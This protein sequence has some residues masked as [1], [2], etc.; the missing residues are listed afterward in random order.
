MKIKYSIPTVLF[1]CVLFTACEQQQSSSSTELA[2]PVSVTEVQ[3]SNIKK[4][5]ST[6]G[7]AL[8]T[9]EVEL[10]SEMAGVYHLQ[11]NPRTKQP[12]KLGDKVLSKDF[13][14]PLVNS[15]ILFKLLIFEPDKSRLSNPS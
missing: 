7:T 2:S 13:P 11:I 6:S 3:L 4:Y 14:K 1:T 12:Y 9:A 8:A 15:L 5:N 10:T